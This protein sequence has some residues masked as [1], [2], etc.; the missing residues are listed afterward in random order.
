MNKHRAFN[1]S[2]LKDLT[3][4]FQ[5]D[6]QEI[7]INTKLKYNTAQSRN[8]GQVLLCTRHA[9]NT[10]QQLPAFFSFQDTKDEI[11]PTLGNYIR[12]HQIKILR[13]SHTKLQAKCLCYKSDLNWYQ[14]LSVFMILKILDIKESLPLEAVSISIKS[15]HCTIKPPNFGQSLFFY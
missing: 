7:C 8:F 13:S 14:E 9:K 2:K 1:Y 6:F 10:H 15:K 5:L 11:F 3:I 4:S 12:Q